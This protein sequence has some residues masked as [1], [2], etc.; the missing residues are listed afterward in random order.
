M[1]GVLSDKLRENLKAPKFHKID[2]FPIGSDEDIPTLSDPPYEDLCAALFPGIL[3]VTPA[4]MK[5]RFEEYLD[6]LTKGKEP[7][8]VPI[9]LE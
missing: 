4:E 2:G 8:K 5:E 3:L 9:V 6:E 7:C 1:A